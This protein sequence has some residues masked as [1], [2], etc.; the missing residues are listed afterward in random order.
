MVR[1]GISALFGW[2]GMYRL[3]DEV[4]LANSLLPQGFA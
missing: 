4:D 1:T 2:I 3:L